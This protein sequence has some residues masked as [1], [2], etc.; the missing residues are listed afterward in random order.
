MISDFK[1]L[2]HL[3]QISRFLS[4]ILIDVFNVIFSI[5]FRWNTTFY[6][7]FVRI[8]KKKNIILIVCILTKLKCIRRDLLTAIHSFVNIPMI[9][10]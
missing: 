6:I 8:T 3:S 5:C 7:I 10:I 1:N 2:V 9:K 4:A